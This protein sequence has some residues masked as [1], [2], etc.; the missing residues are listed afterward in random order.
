[1]TNSKPNV[2][3]TKNGIRADFDRAPLWQRIRAKY[4]TMYFATRV[5]W[6]LFRLLMLI[7]VAFV[8]LYPFYTRIFGSLMA[9]E[10]FV[11]TTVMMVPKNWSLDIYK[12]VIAENHYFE[13]F[14]NTLFISLLC[15][16]CQTFSCSLIAYG[17]AKFRF[18]GN[19]LIF[20]LVIFTM[21][22]PH[23]TVQYALYMFFRYF[24]F[25]GIFKLL[26]GGVIAGLD[27]FPD[28]VNGETA[29]IWKRFTTEGVNLM[30]THWP[31]AIMSLTGLGF[32]NG[33]Y[34]FMLRNFF[35]GV[36]DELEESAYLD[37]SGPFQTFF[38]VI[39]PLSVPTMITVFLFAFCWQWTDQFYSQT[40]Y[41]D[42]EYYLM[43]K[44]V[45]IPDSLVTNYAG[46]NLY[47]SAIRNGCAML[48]IMPLIILYLFCQRYL[49]Q[50][51]ERTGITG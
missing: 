36:P 35:I 7:G 26:G 45:E 39:L 3:I 12:T 2:K 18:R 14:G 43:Y 34:V 25:L 48:I 46:Q 50:G 37:G 41:T 8:V 33:L 24:D 44:I 22:V 20:L 16:F 42:M 21:I 15:A 49:V 51:I 27:I 23:K 17:L 9:P 31:M 19:N 13:A 1:M 6:Y 4:L 28:Y 40:F 5:V 38:R 47:Y 30:N 29:E 11:D 10:D 32:K